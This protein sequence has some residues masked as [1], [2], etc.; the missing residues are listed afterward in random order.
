MQKYNPPFIRAFFLFL[1]L[2]V[3]LLSSCDSD[4][5]KTLFDLN[6]RISEAELL[7]QQQLQRRQQRQRQREDVFHFGFD[8]RSSP[9]EDARQYLPFLKFLEKSTGYQ[10]KLHFIAKNSDI[11]DELGRNQVQFA[12]IGA[13]SFITAQHRYGVVPLVR[14]INLQGKAE[15]RSVF[16]VRP[17]SKLKDITDIKYQHLAFGSETST[18]GHLIP[19]IILAEH[20]IGLDEL[21]SYAFTGSHQNCANA[22]VSGKFGI[23]AM[24]DTMAMTMAEQGLVRILYTSEYY[25]S[26]GIA[27]NGDVPAE[28]VTN[29]K[30]ALLAFQPQTRDKLNLHNWDETEMPKGFVEAKNE[31][32]AKLQTW[33]I[34]L[35]FIKLGEQRESNP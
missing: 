17:D 13:T 28:V 11:I 6:D 30:N 20:N 9:Q 33:A 25:P 7:D 14:G 27:T 1:L 10:F 5:D 12:A 23:C 15:Y 22:V 19:R 34:R 24:Q 16:V 3:W 18:Q 8:L 21:A 32:Y 35:G 31:D 2:P 4:S 26:S 29:V